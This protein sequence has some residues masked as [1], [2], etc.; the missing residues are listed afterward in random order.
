M[1]CWR[2][3]NT[4]VAAQFVDIHSSWVK[5]RKGVKKW[6]GGRDYK[7]YVNVNPC[8]CCYSYLP[9]LYLIFLGTG[10]VHL[11]HNPNWI[12]THKPRRKSLIIDVVSREIFLRC[13]SCF[14]SN[15]TSSKKLSLTTLFKAALHCYNRCP[16]I[17][18]FLPGIYH[19][20]KM[21]YL[22]LV[23]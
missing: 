16:L 13:P 8:C 20:L 17:L 2:C 12:L 3:L 21:L 1:Q 7:L 5:P 19:Y 22:C 23:I 11:D 18:F 4:E 6:L 15:A 10:Q 9:V 14:T